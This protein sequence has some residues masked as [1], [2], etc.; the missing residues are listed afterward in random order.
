VIKVKKPPFIVKNC[1]FIVGRGFFG[2]VELSLGYYI[3]NRRQ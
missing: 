3:K 2:V 1:I